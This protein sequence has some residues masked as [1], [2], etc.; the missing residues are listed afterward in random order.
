MT[1]SDTARTTLPGPP[2]IDPDT[3][4]PGDVM[5]DTTPRPVPG[6]LGRYELTISDNYRI[7][8]AFGGI[9]MA[10]ALRAATTELDRPDLEP[11][12]AD[13]TYCQAI[14]CG[15]VA[16]QVE[17]LRQG[18][19]GS[20]ALVRMWALD[21]ADPDPTG[22]VRS[23][24]VLTVV[25]GNRDES[26][27]GFLGEP[28]PDVGGPD[29]YRPRDVEKGS[30]FERIP[31]HRQNEFR[32]AK[33]FATLG[34]VSPPA[35]PRTASWFRFRS[36]PMDGTGRWDPALL[37]APGDILGPAAHAGLGTEIGFFLVVSMSI[38]MHFVADARSD[39]LLQ[40]T[41]AHVAADGFCSGTA[42]LFDE[43]GTLVAVATQLAKLSP[44]PAMFGEAAGEGEA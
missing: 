15:P 22:E 40:D 7:F 14:P 30:P 6:I 39:W 31:Y 38:T 10:A 19:N 5:A 2:Q 28:R 35:E 21:P 43:H 41:V 1:A 12:V 23:D 34:A 17:V 4:A 32:P 24:L 36:S 37:C 18:R 3:L 8:Y 26:P 16:V 13:S 9:T 42:R 44:L 29:D 33:G 27:Y 25:Y 11:V 20:Q